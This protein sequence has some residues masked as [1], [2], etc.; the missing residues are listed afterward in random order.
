MSGWI[1]TQDAMPEEGQEVT[2]CMSH[3]QIR[4]VVKDKYYAG[5]WK[6]PN[7]SGWESV[8]LYSKGVTHWRVERIEPPDEYAMWIPTRNAVRVGP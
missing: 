4:Q 5:G 8:T 7:C 2:V 3:G 6:Q 1:S